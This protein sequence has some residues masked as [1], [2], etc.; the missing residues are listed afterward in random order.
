[1]F[2]GLLRKTKLRKKMRTKR[3]LRTKWEQSKKHSRLWP[4]KQKL[5]LNIFLSLDD[6]FIVCL[7]RK[8]DRRCP[9]HNT[10]KLLTDLFVWSVLFDQWSSI[11]LAELIRSSFD[12]RQHHSVRCA[13]PHAFTHTFTELCCIFEELTMH[14]TAYVCFEHPLQCRK[15]MCK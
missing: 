12:R 3:Q 15:H 10:K 7:W 1:M 14:G 2:P 13:L 11:P 9:K 4:W 5:F 6:A 8:W